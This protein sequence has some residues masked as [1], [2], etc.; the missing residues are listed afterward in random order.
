MIG[1]LLT[2]LMN[3]SDSASLIQ[4]ENVSKNYGSFHA[5]RDVS[6]DV[7]E[8]EIVGFLG[9]NGAGKTTAM[10]ILSGFFPPTSGRVF[11]QGVDMFKQPHKAKRAIGYLPET[12]SLYSDMRVIEYLRSWMNQRTGWIRPRS[13]RSVN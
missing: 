2:A 1:D 3:N 4:F 5:L 6:F 12:V 9:P 11:V 10:R 13:K 8:G 7:K